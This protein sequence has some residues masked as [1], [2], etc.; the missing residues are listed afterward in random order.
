MENCHNKKGKH[1]FVKLQEKLKKLQ[2][3]VIIMLILEKINLSLKEF[4]VHI[5]GK[6]YFIY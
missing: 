4:P 1:Y 6:K 3:H 5:K 2:D